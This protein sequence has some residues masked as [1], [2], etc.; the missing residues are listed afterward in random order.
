MIVGIITPFLVTPQQ[1]GG[2][3]LA[4]MPDTHC[5]PFVIPAGNLRLRFH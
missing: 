2:I 5:S 1:S 4:P 3:C